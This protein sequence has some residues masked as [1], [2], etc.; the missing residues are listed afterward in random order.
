MSKKFEI[1]SKNNSKSEHRKMVTTAIG[2]DTLGS[3]A[4][5]IILLIY[6]NILLISYVLRKS[7]LICK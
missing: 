7:V 3:T 5:I 2:K 6:I 1:F 4:H